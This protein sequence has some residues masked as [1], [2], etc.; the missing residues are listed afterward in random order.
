MAKI[1]DRGASLDAETRP[2]AGRD[3]DM[4]R[5]VEITGI[6]PVIARARGHR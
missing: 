4:P 6:A 5:L 3:G 2:H 1:D